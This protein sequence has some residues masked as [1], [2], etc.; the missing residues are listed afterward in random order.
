ML[1]SRN[2]RAF[3][4]PISSRVAEAWGYPRTRKEGQGLHQ[5]FSSPEEVVH[6]NHAG[7]ASTPAHFCAL[8]VYPINFFGCACILSYRS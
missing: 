4:V 8:P 5:G 7:F 1:Y 3:L 2:A 6:S